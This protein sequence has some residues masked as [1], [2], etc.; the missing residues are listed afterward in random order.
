[1]TDYYNSNPVLSFEVIEL[2]EKPKLS[3]GVTANAAPCEPNIDYN[4]LLWGV[5]IIMNHCAI[6]DANTN[7]TYMGKIFGALTA[8]PC[9]LACLA[10][11][12][13]YEAL[14]HQLDTASSKCDEQ[15]AILYQVYIIGIWSVK[16]IC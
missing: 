5:E 8:S 1:M 6:L 10:I 4:Y 12:T 15:G 16:E 9:N 13:H 3:F 7:F 14:A 2:K 11:A